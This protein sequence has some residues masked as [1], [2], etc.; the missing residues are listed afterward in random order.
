[1]EAVILAGIQGSGKTTFAL[2]RFFQTHVRL[3]LDQLKTRQKENILLHAC[4]AAQQP[5]VIDNTNVTVAARAHYLHLAKAAG[6][7][8][9]LYFFET[10]T[11]QAIGRNSGRPAKQRVPNLA[12]LGS[13]K[14]QQAP[15]NQEGFDEIHKVRLTEAGFQTAPL[16]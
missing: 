12:I 11:R 5:F 4:L 16:Q 14:K 10:T 9:V 7:R 3:S 6:F 15:T 8:C 2:E 1:M 13:Y